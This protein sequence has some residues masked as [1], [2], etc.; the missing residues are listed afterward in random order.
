VSV[1]KDKLMH[2]EDETDVFVKDPVKFI[3]NANVTED[4]VVLYDSLWQSH[5][6]LFDNS[7]NRTYYVEVERVWNGWFMMDERRRGDIVLLRRMR[8]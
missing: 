4:F 2:Y 8:R 6:N 1:S 5:P 3:K 7:T